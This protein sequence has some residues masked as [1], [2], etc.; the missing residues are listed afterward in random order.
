MAKEIVFLIEE[1]LRVDT[2]LKPWAIP[3][4]QKQIIG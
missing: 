2:P 4:L 1:L 3:S